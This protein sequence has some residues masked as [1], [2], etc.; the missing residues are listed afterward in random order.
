VNGVDRKMMKQYSAIFCLLVIILLA[1]LVFVTAVSNLSCGSGEA[2]AAQLEASLRKG[3]IA[4]YAADGMY[5]SNL[6][7][8]EERCGIG[9]D[10]KRYAV[11]YDIF[12]SNRMP[13]ITVLQNG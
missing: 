5:P 7:E 2:A 4:C 8:L 3:A 1:A 11:H 9:I 6:K 10:R 13:E 12:A